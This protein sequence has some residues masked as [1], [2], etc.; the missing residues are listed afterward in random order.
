[1]SSK[2]QWNPGDKVKLVTGGPDMAV[3]IQGTKLTVPLGGTT[4][5]PSADL[6]LCQW[7]DKDGNLCHGE[8]A[9]ES[10]VAVK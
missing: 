6:V 1:M 8:F 7:F 3:Q 2:I 5:V 10:L 9:P 4:P